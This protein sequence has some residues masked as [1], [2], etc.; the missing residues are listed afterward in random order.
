MVEQGEVQAPQEGLVLPYGAG[1]TYRFPGSVTSAAP[2][3]S[4]LPFS[5]TST[6]VLFRNSSGPDSSHHK[7]GNLWDN[8]PIIILLF[9]CKWKNF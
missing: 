1:Y 6:S 7:H 8:L 3:P 5:C 9:L 4:K 2:A